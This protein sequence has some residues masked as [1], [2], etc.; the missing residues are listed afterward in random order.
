[1]A[2]EY[3][4]ENDFVALTAQGKR[5][6]RRQRRPGDPG[7]RQGLPIVYVM[8]WYQRFPVGI[9]SP[10]KLGIDSPQ[11]LEDTRSHTG[12]VWASY[13]G[14]KALVYAA[15]LNEAAIRLETIGYTQSPR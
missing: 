7:A 8:K 15:K 11:K 5:H 9:M 2:L 6:S 14:W 13:V 4:F 12:P 1:V 10:A 3:G